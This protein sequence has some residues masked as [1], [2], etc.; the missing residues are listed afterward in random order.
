MGLHPSLEVVGCDPREKNP[1]GS[2]GSYP[3]KSVVLSSASKYWLSYRI[4][5]TGILIIIYQPSIGHPNL[6]V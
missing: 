2:R 4:H 6:H 5:A 3:E 1:F